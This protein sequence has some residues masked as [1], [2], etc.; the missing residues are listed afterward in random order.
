M[1]DVVTGVPEAGGDRAAHDVAGGAGIPVS[2]PQ[3]ARDGRIQ[4]EVDGFSLGLQR[5]V[6]GDLL[7]ITDGEQLRAAGTMLARMHA[8]RAHY[9]EAIPGDEPARPG[10]Q[11]VGNDFR[12]AN[13]L[14]PEGRIAAVLDLEEATYRR[15][16]DDLAQA[17]VL[18][19]TRYHDWSPTPSEVRGAF[20][21]AYESGLPLTKDERGDLG[22][23]I[24]A[25]LVRF[26]WSG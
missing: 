26:G 20:V 9:P 22:G 7:D 16:V 5:V 13:I 17:A 14:W 10:T 24:E 1:V 3:A 18:L 19:G 15:R 4:V 8:A 12:A 25:L 6:D 11:L 2:A 21:A 23:A